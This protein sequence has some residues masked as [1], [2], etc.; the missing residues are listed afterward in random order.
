MN[1]PK[2]LDCPANPRPATQN[3]PSSDVLA[4]VSEGAMR[5]F[6]ALDRYMERHLL[7]SLKPTS[8]PHLPNRSEAQEL[9]RDGEIYFVS[10]GEGGPIKVGFTS[11]F[12]YR[13]KGLQTACPY[14]LVVLA[15]VDGKVIAER[16]YHRRWAE[17]KLLGEWFEPHPD[18]LAE[19][20]RLQ[21]QGDY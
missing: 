14:P 13:I 16:E 10:Y 18:I 11:N 4:S 19:I 3:R 1:V 6:D 17:H 9:T 15:R 21:T 8:V 20:D 2:E 12:D 5:A 7:H